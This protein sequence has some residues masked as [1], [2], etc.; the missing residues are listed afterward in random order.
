MIGNRRES[1][2]EREREMMGFEEKT[3]TVQDDLDNIAKVENITSLQFTLL[4][5]NK[6]WFV[7]INLNMVLDPTVLKK[8]KLLTDFEYIYMYILHSLIRIELK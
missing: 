4:R 1:I 3:R 8:F 7:T 2:M 6:M 5:L